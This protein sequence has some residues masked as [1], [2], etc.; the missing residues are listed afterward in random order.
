M[1]YFLVIFITVLFSLQAVGQ[2]NVSSVQVSGNDTTAISFGKEIA[3][4]TIKKGV[5]NLLHIYKESEPDTTVQ[6]FE[7]IQQK[8]V[9]RITGWTSAII[10][11]HLFKTLQAEP[12][13]IQADFQEE[14]GKYIKA[15]AS[16]SLL[17]NQVRATRILNP[18]GT[19]P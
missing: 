17:K 9:D 6:R 4:S 13:H 15:H 3:D 14:T 19:K 16:D 12:V 10:P 2:Q 11:I 5:T 18:E 7:T 8:M 1:R